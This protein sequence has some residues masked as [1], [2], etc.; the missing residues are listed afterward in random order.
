MDTSPFKNNREMSNDSNF[1]NKLAS[2]TEAAIVI[3][4]QV[5]SA[6]EVRSKCGLLLKAEVNIFW[7]RY[8]H[9]QELLFNAC[10]GLLSIII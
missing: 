6:K 1:W 4:T 8:I 3:F 7:F 5:A 2:A 9:E 10:A